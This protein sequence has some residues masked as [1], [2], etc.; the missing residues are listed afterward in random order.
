M[1]DAM[2][3]RWVF[4]AVGIALIVFLSYQAWRIYLARDKKDDDDDEQ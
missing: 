3:I 2:I 1:I 4:F